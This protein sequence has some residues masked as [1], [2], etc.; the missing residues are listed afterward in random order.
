MPLPLRHSE[1]NPHSAPP[2]V[3]LYAA[4]RLRFENRGLLGSVSRSAREAQDL[5]ASLKAEIRERERTQAELR[6]HRDRLESVVALRTDELSRVNR[7]LREALGEK[8][9]MEE[10]RRRLE[11]QLL[12]A[13]KME[14]LATLAGGVAHDFNN[15]LMGIGGQ[16]SLL[17]AGRREG[18]PELER[19]AAME[20]QVRQGAELTRQLLGLAMGGKYEVKTV[21]V[22][23]LVRRVAGL[24]ART[25]KEVRVAMRLEEGLGAV[26]ADRGQIEQALLNICLNAAQAMPGGGVVDLSTRRVSLDA[27]RAAACG[28]RPGEFAVIAVAD[29]GSGMDRSVLPRIFD[30]FFTTRGPAGE[31]AGKGAGLGLSSAYGIVRNHGGFIDVESE[32]GRGSVFSLHLPLSAS[33]PGTGD[34]DLRES[35]PGER[36]V[37]VVDD[38]PMVAEVAA[39]MLQRLGLRPVQALG[40]EAALAAYSGSAER[41]VLVLL[42][43]IMPG[44]GGEETFRRLKALDPGVRVLLSSGYSQEGRAQELLREGCRGFL[45]KPYNL[46]ELR[47]KLEEVLGPLAPARE[48]TGGP[49]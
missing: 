48:G 9:R 21:D 15:L 7:G 12:L 3:P 1:Q 4:I 42:D 34:S 44:M 45:Q 27:A 28:A 30:P 19:L 29:T 49:G 18:D 23:A 38:E 41:P 13:R 20:R 32:R 46:D 5:N 39:L 40:G 11:E 36:T 43:M 8:T 16:I 14:S 6:E 33:A 22:N 47:A 26:D 31:G 35:G 2:G 25:H 17:M 24:F 37:L 10:E